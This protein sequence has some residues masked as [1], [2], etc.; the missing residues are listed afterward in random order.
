[1]PSAGAWQQSHGNQF[2]LEP[3]IFLELELHLTGLQC[4]VSFSLSSMLDF[5]FLSISSLWHICICLLSFHRI[6]Q[7]E[8]CKSGGL[9]DSGADGGRHWHHIPRL[10]TPGIIVLHFAGLTRKRSLN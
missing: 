4:C 10:R 3:M 5:D 2:C 1:M 7:S 9:R 6:S 8:E